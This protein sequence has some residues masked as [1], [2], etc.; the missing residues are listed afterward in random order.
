MESKRTQ[1]IVPDIEILFGVDD[2]ANESTLDACDVS[3]PLECSRR[4]LADHVAF[5]IREGSEQCPG[6]LLRPGQVRRAEAQ[7]DATDFD[8]GKVILR[9]V[10][11]ER[12][13]ELGDLRVDEQWLQQR[14][15]IDLLGALARRVRLRGPKSVK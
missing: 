12:Q 1:G 13:K 7:H 9:S 3:D 15:D 4:P 8:T 14:H 11:K 6:A 2:T 10:A 5:G